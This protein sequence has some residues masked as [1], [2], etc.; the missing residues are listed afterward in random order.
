[1][2]Q[3]HNY[4]TRSKIVCSDP[5]TGPITGTT[6]T[7]PITDTPVT[8]TTV[9]DPITNTT[10]ADTTSNTVINDLVIREKDKSTL[11]IKTIDLR[12][13]KIK[14]EKNAT[15]LLKTLIF[16]QTLNLMDDPDYEEYIPMEG[17]PK[18]VIYM[19]SE[20]DYVKSLSSEEQ[21]KIF[22]ME[23][24]IIDFNKDEIPQRFKILNSSL[25]ITTKSTIIKK[26][27]NFYSMEESD[28]EY[29]KLSQ[30]ADGINKIPFDIYS[31]SSVTLENT[32]S[33]IIDYLLDIKS[34]LDASVYGHTE[35]KEQILQEITNK[36]SNP[37][38]L[39]NCIA[40]Q[41]PP[42]NGKTTLIKEGV[43]KAL[44][45]PFAFIAL[46]GMQ[47]SEFLLGHDYTYEG[48]RPGRIVE[49]LQEC[50]TM[51][52][53]IYFD[54][55]DKLSDSPKGEEIANLLCHLTDPS[56]N[57]SFH[58]K[59]YSGIDF[60]LSK[61]TFIFSYNDESKISPILLDRMI[62]IKTNGF[63][64]IHKETIAVEYLLPYIYKT[65]NFNALDTVFSKE[66]IQYIITTYTEDEKGVRNLKRSL[67]SIVSKINI[68][69]LLNGNSTNKPNDTISLSINDYQKPK[70]DLI[71]FSI[72]KFKLPLELNREIIDNL[73]KRPSEDLTKMMMYT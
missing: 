40:I 22:M 6:V 36:I 64:N 24:E 45:R 67:T 19:E 53:V 61:A 50:K 43:C 60:N 34:I 1:M 70:N 3:I 30:W 10:V 65:I 17:L 5:N 47:N 15:E 2:E 14:L 28:N 57:M 38:S 20:V 68:L 26:L 11:P 72:K 71:T 23:Q 12:T 21:N 35:A 7:D 58:D 73:L 56:Q 29:S 31:K 62:K 54:E 18:T 52:P 41:G 27:D 55:L 13:N 42:G 33:E 37:K 32:S 44:K 4:N 25:N 9:T 49:I 8:N 63:S 39:G 59:Y 69:K 51:D 16:E 46:G 66:I 48:S